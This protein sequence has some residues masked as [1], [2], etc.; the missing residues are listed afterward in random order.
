MLSSVGP[1]SQ[2]LVTQSGE[3]EYKFTKTAAYA[4]DFFVGFAAGC[5]PLT[6][7]NSITLGAAACLSLEGFLCC[8]FGVPIACG[9]GSGG[10]VASRRTCCEEGTRC[11]RDAGWEE[12]IKPSH[13]YPTCCIEE[14]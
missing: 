1:E 4:I 10:C 14:V 13:K 11:Y 12:I 3:T 2:S 6:V 8:I 7:I 5:L 9:L